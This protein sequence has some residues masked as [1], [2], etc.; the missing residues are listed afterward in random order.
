MKVFSTERRK[1]KTIFGIRAKESAKIGW[2]LATTVVMRWKVLA[3][4][5]SSEWFSM[6]SN[7][8]SH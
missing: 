5:E 7:Y 6:L 8:F 2:V 3:T 4:R 1:T